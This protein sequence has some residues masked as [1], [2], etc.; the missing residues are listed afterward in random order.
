MLLASVQGIAPICR[1]LMP[2][3]NIPQRIMEGTDRRDATSRQSQPDKLLYK[4]GQIGA[5]TLEF[6]AFASILS[7]AR[8]VPGSFKAQSSL[9]WVD[10]EFGTGIKF[11]IIEG[12]FGGASNETDDC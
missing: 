2:E 6:S 11:L 12:L 7:P 8:Y 10:I 4:L 3:P 5:T 1:V 9:C